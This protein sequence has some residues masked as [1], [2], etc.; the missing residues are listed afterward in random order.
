LVHVPAGSAELEGDLD[1]PEGAE[2]IVLFAHGGGSTRFSPRDRF[3]A[4]VLQQGGLATLLIDLLT[5]EEG[6]VDRYTRHLRSDIDL[7]AGRVAR[8]TGWIMEQAKTRALNIGYFGSSSG[9]A[10]ALAAA[11]QHPDG[12]D[13]IVSR[14]GRLDLAGQ[15]LRYVAVP[16]LL[17]VGSDDVQALGLNRHALAQLHGEKRL[18]VV[19]GAGH[20][21]EEPG[22][23]D[24]VARL[25][26][27]W[28]EQHLN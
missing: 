15:A 4:G 22:A 3:V 13:A 6:D 11:A 21:F 7:L 25:A 27:R 18:E 23:L 24:L 12:I 16:T 14:G 28:F 1:I 2:G 5:P 17:V 9:A 26:R 20:L 10:V 19:P 8:A